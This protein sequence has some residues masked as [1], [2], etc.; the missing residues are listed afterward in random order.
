MQIHL[1]LLIAVGQDRL[2]D[3]CT[4]RGLTSANPGGDCADRPITD[5][6]EVDDIGSVQNREM[7]D[8]P[9]GAMQ[10]AQQRTGRPNEAVLVYGKR[11]QLHQPHAE[12]VVTTAAA[13][14]AQLHQPIEHPVRRR[15]RQSGAADDL[16][17][18][19]PSRSV[20]CIEDQRDAVDDGAGGRR[21]NGRNGVQG[22][23]HRFS[24]LGIS[25]LAY[26]Y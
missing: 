2:A 14:P 11:A 5:L 23:G 12:L 4:V 19:Q 18:C 10:F 6:L 3:G 7:H 8:E 17:Q 13:Q 25:E 24:N 9:G 15:A 20:E 1:G 16:G 22:L 21:F 26:Y